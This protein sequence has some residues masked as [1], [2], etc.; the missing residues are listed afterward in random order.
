MQPN[1]GITQ[2]SG[3]NLCQSR[4]KLNIRKKFF[5]LRVV[6]HWKRLP[7]DAPCLSVSKRH[8]DNALNY[9]LYLFICPEAVRQLD[10]MIFQGLFHPSYSILFH[11]IPCYFAGR[12]TEAMT[13]FIPVQNFYYYFLFFLSPPAPPHP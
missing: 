4:F 3:R 1:K 7:R 5:S 11:S 12:Q 8:L 9:I 2:G 10:K 6:K 13:S